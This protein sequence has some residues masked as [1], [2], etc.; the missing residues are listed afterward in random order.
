P[1]KQKKGHGIHKWLV[2]FTLCINSIV[3]T[4]DSSMINISMPELTGTF[5]AELST[6][7][8]ILLAFMLTT[9]G[10]LLTL[11]KA[12]DVLGRKQIYLIGSIL[13]TLGLG[14]CALSQ[15][16]GQLIL[17]R[18]I[19]GVGMAMIV[20]MGY[21][22]VTNTFGEQ[23]R[24]KAIGILGTAVGIGLMS[25]PALGGFF[26]DSFGWR[27]IFYL[28]LP[29]SFLAVIMAWVVLRDDSSSERTGGFDIWGSL[30]LF[31][32]LA[33]LLF[34][35]NQGQVRGWATP[36]VLAF[37]TGSLVLLAI[38]I[39]IESRLK[40]PVLELSIFKHTGFTLANASLF[41]IFLGRRGIFLILPFL[42]IQA[43]E[44]SA[45]MTG[46]FLMVNP[47]TM[48][49]LAP[50]SGWLSDKVGSR[51]LC[52][53]GIGIACFSIILLRE[54]DVNSTWL[55][56]VLALLVGGIGFSIFETPNNSFIMG[57]VSEQKLGT[58]S[59]L[60]ATMRTIGQSAG[61]AIAAAVFSSRQIYHAT[62]LPVE[63]ALFAGFRDTMG[64]TLF[65]CGAA[66]LAS[67]VHLK[68]AR[69]S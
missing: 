11:G 47:L 64:V 37:L 61:L 15:N 44:Y 9:S 3:G 5:E 27:S 35:I 14:L 26:L 34:A 39:I 1:I 60:I 68:A 4:M 18:I 17:F 7:I 45:T 56:I 28:R 31:G 13:F 55:T 59:A 22:I 50:L 53:L 12:G 6:A 58:A 67:L 43:Q 33:G 46:L 52:P 42:L 19:Q 29:L 10:L 54:L 51:F 69:R 49:V 25:G 66:F 65:I 62:N 38:F 20:A 16:I 30:T 57:V 23:D 41:L 48:T 32:G 24:G 21:A 36:F 63:Q 40:Q 2:L 8:W